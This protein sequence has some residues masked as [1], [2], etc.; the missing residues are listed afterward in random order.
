[1]KKRIMSCLL[2]SAFVGGCAAQQAQVNTAP[3]VDTAAEAEKIK[4]L[5]AEWSKRFGSGDIEWIMNLHDAGAV[6]M[7]P[8]APPI[9]GH[10]ALRTQWEGMIKNL[11]A[12]WNPTKVQVAASGDMAYDLGDVTIQGPDGPIPAK[13]VIVWVREG[14][15]WK[16]AVD[17]FSTNQK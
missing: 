7:P 17:M 12:S 13:Y 2:L 4:A 3:S 15:E 16:I 5:E 8:N 9:V 11:K 14:D 10:E 6:Q 1:M